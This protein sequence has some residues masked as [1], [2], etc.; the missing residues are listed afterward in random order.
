LV[1]LPNVVLLPLLEHALIVR[2]IV[3]AKD[4]AVTLCQHPSAS[5][6]DH[7]ASLTELNCMN[8]GCTRRLAP[9]GG[10]GASAGTGSAYPAIA[11]VESSVRLID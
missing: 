9:R 7:R 5:C 8:L 2:N 6:D 3:L 4:P 1:P 11:N 10:V